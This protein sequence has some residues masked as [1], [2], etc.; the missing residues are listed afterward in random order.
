[1]LTFPY[2]INIQSEKARHDFRK[3]LL[4]IRPLPAHRPLDASAVG[5]LQALQETQL[6]RDSCDVQAV[7][8]IGAVWS[9]YSCH[10]CA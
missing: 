9:P 1:M 10:T 2:F 3:V 8:E 5:A 6:V 7:E 4:I